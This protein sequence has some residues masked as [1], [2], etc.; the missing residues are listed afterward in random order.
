MTETTHNQ[1][2]RVDDT[3]DG[4]VRMVVDGNDQGYGT[5][6]PFLLRLGQRQDDWQFHLIGHTEKVHQA[7][8]EVCEN[9]SKD[10][11][12]NLVTKNCNHFAKKVAEN[13]VHSWAP[14]WHLVFGQLETKLLLL[15]SMVTQQTITA[16]V[17]TVSAGGFGC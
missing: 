10:W 15:N 11:N 3:N 2:L 17:A 12:Y 8:V 6:R 14:F 5:S 13:I 7:I 1:S 16:N 4:S 9:V